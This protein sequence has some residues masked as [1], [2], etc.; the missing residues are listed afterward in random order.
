MSLVQVEASLSKF[1]ARGE[2]S[3][4]DCQYLLCDATQGSLRNNPCCKMWV[5]SGSTG[6]SMLSWSQRQQ[7][8]TLSAVYFIVH[9]Q[10]GEVCDRCCCRAPSALASLCN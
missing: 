2:A 10:V 8:G 7:R 1:D 9:F 4:P 3:V 6:A 5:G